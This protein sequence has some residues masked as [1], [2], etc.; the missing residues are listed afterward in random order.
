LRRDASQYAICV[1]TYSCCPG[2][3]SAQYAHLADDAARTQFRPCL[4]YLSKP[5]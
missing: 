5:S 1:G 4:G 2:V 3:A